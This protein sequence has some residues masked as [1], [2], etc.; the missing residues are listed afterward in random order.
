MARV[1]LDAIRHRVNGPFRFHS[2]ADAAAAAS[3]DL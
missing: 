3:R 2:L 1:Y